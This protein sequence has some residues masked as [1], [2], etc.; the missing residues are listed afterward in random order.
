MMLKKENRKELLKEE[1]LCPPLQAMNKSSDD[2]FDFSG[3]DEWSLSIFYVN[4]KQS[5]QQRFLEWTS[6]EKN[7]FYF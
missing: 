6:P 5:N 4:H 3:F 7:P 1:L 2:Y